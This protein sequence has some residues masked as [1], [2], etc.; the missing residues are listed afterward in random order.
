[1]VEP[2]VEEHSYTPELRERILAGFRGDVPPLRPAWT[3]RVALAAVACAMVL[4][5]VGYVALIALCLWVFLGYARFYIGSILFAHTSLPVFFGAAVPLFVGAVLLVFLIKPL[6]ARPAQP[7]SPLRLDPQDE[8]L[9]FAFVARLCAALHARVPREIHVDCQVNASA[10]FRRGLLSIFDDDM[11]LTLGLPLVQGLSLQQLA[12]VM[13]HELGHFGQRAGMRVSF[14]IRTI[15]FWFARLVYGR[16]RLD[17]ILEEAAAER[18]RLPWLRWVFRLSLFCVTLTRRVLRALMMLGHMLS[19]FMMRQME[20][21]ADR[22]EVRLAG[23]NAFDTSMRELFALHAA[24][25]MAIADLQEQWKDGRLVNN[26]PRLV[27]LN[28]SEGVRKIAP[29]LEQ[30]LQREPEELFST[31]PTARQRTASALRE[32]GVG[33]FSSNLPATALFYDVDVLAQ[34]VS[35]AYY[36]QMLGNQ[37]EERNL[38]AF[39]AAQESQEQGENERGALERFFQ[40]PNWLR[41]LPLPPKLPPLP[42]DPQ[43]VHDELEKAR[44]AV[45]GTDAHHAREIQNYREALRGRIDAL[46]ARALRDAGFS[47][48]AGS[49]GLANGDP[50]TASMAAERAESLM[51]SSGVQLEKFEKL[52]VRRL[53]LALVLL[54]EPRVAARLPAAEAWGQEVPRLLACAAFL[55]GIFP[56]MSG[57]RTTRAV[58][59]ILAHQLQPE[60]DNTRLVATITERLAAFQDQL[61]TLHRDLRPQPYPFEHAREGINLA[62]V[63]IPSMP[64][65]ND[66]GGLI[67]MSEHALDRLL[68]VYGRLL[69]RLAWMAEKVEEALGMPPLL[70][71]PAAAGVPEATPETQGP[72]PLQTPPSPAPAVAAPA[73]AE[74]KA[75][76]IESRETFPRY[77]R[78]VIEL[79]PLPVPETAET[80]DARAAV[81]ALREALHAAGGG[82]EAYARRAR[83]YRDAEQRLAKALRAE[84]L[85]RAGLEIEPAGFG[86]T[87][88]DRAAALEGQRQAQAEMAKLEPGLRAFEEIQGQRL[89]NAL[90]LLQD[91]RVAARLADG[92]RRRGEIAPLLAGAAL[93]HSRFPLL[94]GLRDAF[95]ILGGLGAQM[96]AHGESSQLRGH[97][98]E[99]AAH[100]HRQLQDLQRLLHRD[101]HPFATARG[102]TTLAAI[103]VPSLP[104]PGDVQAIYQA[105]SW[106]VREMLDLHQRILGRLAGTAEKVEEA[107]E[108]R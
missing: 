69:G 3:Y 31:H 24:W 23:F 32:K 18:S 45:L 102:A 27:V 94:R 53:G 66:L 83:K 12:G 90:A 10:S 1:M 74:T 17:A 107:L 61:K 48:D 70:R 19:S 26:F 84:H 50:A 47:I 46:Q 37:V 38:I 82:A 29:L 73:V 8:P 96:K 22:Y 11:V 9:L 58:L 78:G 52:E 60:R 89:G 67:G 86:L 71:T 99:Q 103:A 43:V 14:L 68:E 42:A 35:L 80:A 97:F 87:G 20:Y 21:D 79:R 98:T 76:A 25:D 81:A 85:L 95:V 62:Q 63:A 34:K 44:R 4:L 101:P 13:A 93:L 65:A 106:A 7:D 105:T 49:F 56:Q 16:D 100:A 59:D 75:E 2:L 28:R 104:A 36:R 91:G 5:P 15:N 92:E 39:Q 6:F 72:A 55:S 77:F 57:L 51:R 64:A 41:G 108:L 33:V 88:H 40:N 30:F 54:A